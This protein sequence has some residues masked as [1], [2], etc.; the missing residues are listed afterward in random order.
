MVSKKKFK[1]VLVQ[2]DDSTA[3]GIELTAFVRDRNP[4]KRCNHNDCLAGANKRPGDLATIVE[5]KK[6]A[7]R[8]IP[9]GSVSHCTLRCSRL[10]RTSGPYD[11]THSHR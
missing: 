8:T 1:A 5:P 9:P 10:V 6:K 4:V 3:C 7:R 11:S 2:D